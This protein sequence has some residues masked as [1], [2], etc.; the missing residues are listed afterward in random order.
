MLEGTADL[1]TFLRPTLQLLFIFCQMYFVFLNHKM[2]IYRRKFATR[3]GLMHLIATNLCV[4]LKVLVLE[5]WHELHHS[6]RR[7]GAVHDMYTNLVQVRDANS[8]VIT[9]LG[10]EGEESRGQVLHRLVEDSAPFL[11]PC[12]IEFSLISA[13]VLFIM[14]RHVT[15]EHEV[16]RLTITSTIT[17]TIT[18][19]VITVPTTRCTGWP[20]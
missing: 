10:A 20:S 8:L 6:E 17:S 18:I 19:I 14:W 1:A 16:C 5:T 7:E 2:N 4:W 9:D 3:L 11:F 13:A 15:T 12:T